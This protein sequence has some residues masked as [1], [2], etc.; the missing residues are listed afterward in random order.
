[1]PPP[2]TFSVVG[3]M[4]MDRRLSRFQDVVSD[5]RPVLRDIGGL[6]RKIEEEQFLSE[7]HGR[8]RP[9]APATLRRKKG[10]GILRESG[11]LFDSLTSPGGE[12]EEEISK[13]EGR[14]GTAVPYAIF[15]QTGTSKMPTRPP[16]DFRE[17]DKREITRLV[18]RFIVEEARRQGLLSFGGV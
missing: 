1:M 12:H 3:V 16:I 2:L 6:F 10:P 18:Q 15:H 5:Y 17:E 14:W 4:Q 13:T 8:W 7:G 9:L 11:R